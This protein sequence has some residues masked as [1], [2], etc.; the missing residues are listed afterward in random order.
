MPFCKYIVWSTCLILLATATADAQQRFKAGVLF[1]LN[2]SQIYGDDIGGYNKLGLQ[3][4]LRGI[5]VLDEKKEVAVELLYSQRGSYQKDSPFGGPLKIGLQY[6]E[7]PVVFTYKD[8]LDEE[9]G[10]YKIQA[11]GGLSFGRLLKASAEGS[12]FDDITD[13]FQRNDISVTIGAE[14]FTRENFAFGLRWSRS[15]N[16]LYNNKKDPGRNSLVGYFLSFRSLYVF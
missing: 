5:T 1:G 13:E 9:T 10:F 16:R 8:W 6:V 4:G 11:S 2:A 7:I 14:Y 3:G 12:K 15:L